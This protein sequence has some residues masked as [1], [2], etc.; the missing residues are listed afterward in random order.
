MKY[1]AYL[2]KTLLLAVVFASPFA[3]T[4]HPANAQ[5]VQ[6]RGI[7][8]VGINVPDMDAAISFFS[9]TFGF[10][11]VTDMRDIPID[12]AF[13]TTFHMHS[14]TQ[15]KRIVMMRAGKSANLELF[16]YEAPGASK[17]QPY[18][19][20]AAAAYICFYTDDMSRTVA[21][22]RAQGVKVLTDPIVMAQG[23]TA[24]ETWTYFLTPWGAKLE[25]TTYPDGKGYE[26]LGGAA[27]LWTPETPITEPATTEAEVQVLADHYLALLNEHDAAKRLRG[28]EVYFTADA[29]FVDPDGVFTGVSAVNDKIT[30]LQATY[31]GWGFK[32]Y[33]K[34]EVSGALIR[35]PWQFGPSND[36]T[37][38]LGEDV[39]TVRGGKVA[40]LTVFLI[41]RH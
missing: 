33:G 38:V 8:H 13:R 28:V 16:Q 36:P 10:V 5:A 14:G 2:V 24:G 23:P 15:V 19:D 20:D 32:Q 21:A 40:S 29:S 35:V 31:Q 39:I 41:S 9:K 30:S 3:F 12:D 18:Y 4:L 11:P 25:L 17:E 34:V 22:L 7:D 6:V 26:K 27:R 37:K 1:R